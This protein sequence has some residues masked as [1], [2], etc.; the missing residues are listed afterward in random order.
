MYIKIDI[1]AG[2]DQERYSRDGAEEEAYDA[3]KF[4]GATQKEEDTDERGPMGKVSKGNADRKNKIPPIHP[5]TLKNQ[6]V[7]N[8]SVTSGKETRKRTIARRSGEVIFGERRGK[9]TGNEWKISRE[10]LHRANAII[11]H[12]RVEYETNNRCVQ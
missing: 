9:G 10:I 4:N 8:N 11:S 1:E 12:I 5:T 3:S 2:T 6:I 7:M